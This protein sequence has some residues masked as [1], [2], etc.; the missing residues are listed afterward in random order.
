MCSINNTVVAG[1]LAGGPWDGAEGREHSAT[2]GDR[3][4]TAAI[5]PDDGSNPGHVVVYLCS[6]RRRELR[7]F[8]IGSTDSKLK[9]KDNDIT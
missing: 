4:A 9:S 7:Q 2:R 8:L 3:T 1:G 5:V 6:S